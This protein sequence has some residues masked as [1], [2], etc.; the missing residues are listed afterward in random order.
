VTRALR[1]LEPIIGHALPDR[2][3]F[4]RAVLGL[5]PADVGRIDRIC[6]CL[7]VDAAAYLREHRPFLTSAQILRMAAEGF[8]IGAHGRRH[9]PLDSVEDAVLEDEIAGS[10]RWI[11][12][13][14]GRTPVPF[15]F[16]HSADG[17]DRAA[18]QRLRD[19]HPQVGRLFDTRRLRRDVEFICNRIVADAPPL[20]ES[21][22][23]LPMLL[24][25]AYREAA[26]E[27]LRTWPRRWGAAHR[28]PT[29]EQR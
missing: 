7:E 22:T 14:T 23:N 21:T 20:D 18:L 24:H 17:V 8:T 11:A 10:C 27:A 12:G 19:R 5:D 29:G 4:R 6:A 16:P 26:A 28:R 2:A 15:A 25:A 9:L 13:L 3:A 1:A